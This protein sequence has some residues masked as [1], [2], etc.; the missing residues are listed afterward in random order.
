ML[1]R[2]TGQDDIL[3]GIPVADRDRLDLQQLIGFL[4]DTHILRTNLGGNP[5]FREILG[6]VQKSM[7]GLYAHQ[8]VPFQRVVEAL[9][10]E[11]SLSYA[12]LFQVLLNWR[13]PDAEL[14]FIGFPGLEVESLLAQS[15]ISKFDLTFFVT[16]TSESI[17]LEVE[18]NT[19][20]FEADRIERM[21]DHFRV[22]LEGAARDPEQGIAEMPMLTNAERQALLTQWDTVAAE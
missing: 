13:D 19:D 1:Y 5:S 18:Y 4:L 9:N 8:S 12:P 7:L 22:L 16:E 20:L 11:R 14:R 21:F 10:P 15:K 2:Y 3:I 6:R 17:E